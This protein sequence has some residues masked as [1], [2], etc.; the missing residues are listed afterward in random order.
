MI[1]KVQMSL[2]TNCSSNQVLVYDKNRKHVYEGDCPKEIK[3]VMGE[4]NKKFFNAKLIKGNLS[5][6]SPTGWR[7]W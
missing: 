1:V 2:I 4:E 7:D 6:E 5:L 3:K